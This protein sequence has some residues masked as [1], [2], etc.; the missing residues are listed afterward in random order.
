MPAWCSGLWIWCRGERRSLPAVADQPAVCGTQ[1][2][3]VA[4]APPGRPHSHAADLRCCVDRIEIWR[5]ACG[6]PML[7]AAQL[8]AGKRAVVFAP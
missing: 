7:L 2:P 1:L 8:A 5:P 3:G 6:F 4:A